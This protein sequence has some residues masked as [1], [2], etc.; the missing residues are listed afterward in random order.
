MLRS[1]L[2]YRIRMIVLRFA[3]GS[4]IWDGVGSTE[5]ISS[6]V[7]E[8]LLILGEDNAGEAEGIQMSSA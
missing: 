8:L 7:E 2:C 3:C 6:E 5:I 4:F 1:P